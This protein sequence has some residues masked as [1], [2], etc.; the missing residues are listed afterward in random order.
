MGL[1]NNI[2]T[3]ED[4]KCLECGKSLR[5]DTEHPDYKN[6][7]VFQSKDLAD[8]GHMWMVGE[9]LIL[10]DYGD[11]SLRFVAEGDAVWKGIHSCPH[12]RAFFE[13]DIIIKDGTI[14]EIKN[15]REWEI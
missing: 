4:I 13:C 10:Y 14:K 12:C 3:H 7:I 11:D 5:F 2:G 15:L 6:T 8:R 1:T 9:K